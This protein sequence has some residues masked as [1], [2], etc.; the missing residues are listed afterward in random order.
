M[1][2][3]N[4][5]FV[6]IDDG[7]KFRQIYPSDTTWKTVR[8]DWPAPFRA[9]RREWPSF[10]WPG[11][12]PLYYFTKDN[13]ILCPKCANENLKLTLGNDPQW[14]IV[15]CDINYEDPDTTCDNCWKNIESAYSDDEENSK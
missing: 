2:K 15:D 11:G 13:G 5:E 8:K 1:T 9:I 3:P 10:A 4:I 7:I 6:F 14:Q 12:Y